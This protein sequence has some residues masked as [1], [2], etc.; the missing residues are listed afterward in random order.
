MIRN[1]NSAIYNS[2]ENGTISAKYI[3]F[4]LRGGGGKEGEWGRE[5]GRVSE[6]DRVSEK[7]GESEREKERE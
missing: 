4:C 1:R 2:K 6:N 7:K 3:C 5:S